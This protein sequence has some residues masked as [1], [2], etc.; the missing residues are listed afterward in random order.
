M[1]KYVMYGSE[2]LRWYCYGRKEFMYL[3]GW[4]KAEAGGEI[5]MKE[6]SESEAADNIWLHGVL[7]RQIEKSEVWLK[8]KGENGFVAC[9]NS[10]NM[11]STY[12]AN[13][14]VSNGRRQ[15]EDGG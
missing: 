13:F 4:Y 1:V 14:V 3:K 10:L 15:L 6:R 12:V 2:N 11:Y 5:Y 9:P 7:Y 8:E